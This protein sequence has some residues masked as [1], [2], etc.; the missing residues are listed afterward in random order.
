[1]KNKIHNLRLLAALSVLLFGAST[2][3][4]Q[5][6]EQPPRPSELEAQND[7]R[8]EV[9][10]LFAK[11]E[12]SLKL[13]DQILF[14]AAA[15]DIPLEQPEES[16][17]ASLL[18]KTQEASQSAI[19]DIDKILKISK[20]SKKS[21][22][23]PPKPSDSPPPPGDSPLDQHRDGTP[24]Q[25]EQTPEKP[26]PSQSKPEQPEPK[27]DGQDEPEESGN[28]ANDPQNPSEPGAPV[29][30]NQDG[31]RWG[32]LPPRVREIFRSQ[33]GGDLPTQ[34][35][36]WIDSYYRRLNKRP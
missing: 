22:Q 30:V 33:G 20:N 24:Q 1:M 8:Q 11:V 4:A 35:R 16:G 13:I 6:P 27:D 18:R 14:D 3:N 31:E 15:G 17:L 21:N 2:A 9:Q 25:Q 36:D 23:G 34:Y 19:N 29:G 5:E 10:E 32:E 26:E 7:V 28:S 12:R